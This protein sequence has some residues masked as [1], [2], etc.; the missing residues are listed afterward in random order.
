MGAPILDRWFAI[1]VR[2]RSERMVALILR[3]KGYDDFVPLFPEASSNGNKRARPLF[4]GYVFCRVTTPVGGPIVT[5]PGVVRVVGIGKDPT[6]VPDE[7]IESIR[8]LI[9]SGLRLETTCDVGPGEPVELVRG[10][11]SGCRGIVKT[12]KSRRRLVVTISL[13]QRSVSVELTPDCIR[14]VPRGRE[15]E[16]CPA[17]V[18][19][20]IAS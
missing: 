18:G 15:S 8:I 2:P 5:T 11:L 9:A 12:T 10:P 16:P 3:H 14:R 6:P 17:T 13:L 7:E 19:N 20:L 1:Q 4:P